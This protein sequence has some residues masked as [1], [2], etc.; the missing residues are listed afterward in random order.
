ME[1]PKLKKTDN[2]PSYSSKNFTSFCKE[3][4]IKHKTGNL[5]NPI[6]KGLVQ[7]AHRTLKNWLLKAK[8]G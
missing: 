8:Q 7:C 4:G 2:R 1:L 5:Y 3:F 6:G